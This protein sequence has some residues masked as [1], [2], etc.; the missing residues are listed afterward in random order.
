M[1]TSLI[2]LSASW[3]PILPPLPVPV[4]KVIRGEETQ[5]IGMH[6]RSF[7]DLILSHNVWDEKN[8]HSFL[9]PAHKAGS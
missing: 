3:L 4:K 5:D 6:W 8:R 7:G 1:C 9:H 2:V